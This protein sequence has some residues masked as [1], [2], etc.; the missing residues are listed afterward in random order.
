MYRKLD[1]NIFFNH[2][3]NIMIEFPPVNDPVYRCY[4][5]KHSFLTAKSVSVSKIKENRDSGR[6]NAVLKLTGK[7]VLAKDDRS[8]EDGDFDCLV[9]ENTGTS[10][11]PKQNGH[12]HLAMR[13]DSHLA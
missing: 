7:L 5:P 4:N 2:I 9:E 3:I 1:Y 13:E 8:E 12:M 11:W 6:F 10:Y